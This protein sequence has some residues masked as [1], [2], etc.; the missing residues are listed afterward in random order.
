MTGTEKAAVRA[1]T[2]PHKAILY[3]DSKKISP[4]YSWILPQMQK[5]DN[6]ELSKIDR[7]FVFDTE[8]RTDLCQNLTFGYFEV[9]QRKSLEQNG[10]FYDE[11]VTTPKEQKILKEYCEKN[12]ISL[13]TLQQ[14]R[15]IFLYEV[16]GLNSTCIGFNLQFDLNHIALN[17]TT[18]RMKKNEGFSL[19][20]SKNWDYPRLLITPI[21]S[22]LSF[23]SWGGPMNNDKKKKPKRIINNFVDLRTLCHA[24]TDKK[25]SLE[26]AC[27]AFKTDYKKYKV[28][29]HGKVNAKYIDY[30]V[31]DVKSTFS[32]F[33][34]AKEE[35]EK[36]D[37][38][39]PFSKVYTPASI[40]KEFL[41][42]MGVKSF[43]WK[44]PDF[45]DEIIG[46]IMSCYYGGR[47]ECKIRKKPLNVDLLD[48]LSM[49]PTVCTLQNLWR[50]VIADKIKSTEATQEIID[51]VDNF[52]LD[53]VRDKATWAKLQSI[54]LVEPIDDVLPI[55]AQFG[56]K[57]AWNIG[58]SQ[59]S[60]TPEPMWY[61]LADVISSKL[62]TGKPPKI[63][64]AIKFEPVG[65]QENLKNTNIHGTTVN[66]HKDDLFKKLIEY[67]QQQK[68]L[69]DKSKG[70][71]KV[72]YEFYE[73]KQKIIK[74]ITNAISYGIYVEVTAYDNPIK[75]AIDTYGLNQ[76]QVKKTRM[77]EPGIMFNPIIAVAITSAARLLLASAEAVLQRE[78]NGK[79]SHAYCDTDSMIVPSKYTNALQKFFYPLNPYDVENKKD[80][81]VF[82]IEKQNI[83]F[84][85]ISAKRYCL[86]NIDENG[87]RT[88]DEDKTSSHGLGHLLNPFS[89]ES[90]SDEKEKEDWHKEIWSDI[91]DLEYGDVT[92]EELQDKYEN[93]YALQKLALSKPS[94]VKRLSEFNKGKEYHK[95]IKPSNFGILGFARVINPETDEPI[96]PMAPFR[97]P[98]K[99]A[100][101]DYFLDYNDKT[102]EK[103]LRGK[104]YWKT[105]WEIFRDYISHPEAKFDGDLGILERKHVEISE[106]VHIGKESNAIS[107]D[108]ELDEESYQIYEDP[109]KIDREFGKI[110]NKVLKLKPKDVKSLGI[111][112]P[113][114]WRAQRK[115]ESSEINRISN[116]IKNLLISHVN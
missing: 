82:E 98:A 20:L 50:F 37:L 84:Y 7:Y 46:N 16:Y 2:I 100:V 101:H 79:E 8:T 91:L 54:V 111:T 57:H 12:N 44:N 13:F 99:D 62:Y 72:D 42:M 69:R 39:I 73:R 110:A 45:S 47:T 97:N 18:A 93:K 66:P 109:N 96:K 40:G 78:S 90:D 36:Y 58:I 51:F 52:E 115:I 77:E 29:E 95:Q 114:L 63:L 116:R 25:H 85:G 80:V 21:S 10:I 38:P 9:Y 35:F 23:I 19:E 14:F 74:I 105:F 49:Y 22:T 103:K 65:V 53:H 76:F 34:N 6:K 15:Q 89:T 88:V 59:I 71:S 32:L 67:R 31:N 60:S 94:L 70:N 107:I 112:K 108:E 87:K 5:D 33:L 30:C 28:Q 55:R 64:K 27:D 81:Q 24:L 48:F 26:S 43:F 56:D 1:F 75:I 113:T 4:F 86:F 106:I 11:K 102:N 41:N 68:V 17:S 83:W 3:M 92:M 104:E 61:S